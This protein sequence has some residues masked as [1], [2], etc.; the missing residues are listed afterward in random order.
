MDMEMTVNIKEVKEFVTSKKFTQFLLNNT[1]DFSVAGYIL[2]I[3]MNEIER[4]E[5]LPELDN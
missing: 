3:L 5:A 2:T 1:T 4:V